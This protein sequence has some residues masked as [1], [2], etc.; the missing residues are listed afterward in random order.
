[1]RWVHVKTVVFAAAACGLP[2]PH[3][4]FSVALLPAWSVQLVCCVCALLL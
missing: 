3:L 1:M 2:L 4:I